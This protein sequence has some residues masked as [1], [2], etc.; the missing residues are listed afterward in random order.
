MALQTRLSNY[1]VNQQADSLAR[2]LDLGYMR[3]YSGVQPG[4]A[5]TPVSNQVLLAELRFAATSAPGAVN[6]VLTFNPITSDTAADET[7]VATWFRCV[8]SDGTTVVM[9]GSV[10]VTGST[11]NLELATN[12][13][14][15]NAQVTVTS[16]THSVAKSAAG[17]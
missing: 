8:S 3:L 15:Q 17:F 16:F 11:S 14:V 7:G 12:Q 13:I 10:G 9:D 2:A 4:N 6:G 1:I 5:D